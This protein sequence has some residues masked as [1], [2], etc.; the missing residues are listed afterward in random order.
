MRSTLSQC[1]SV[2]QLLSLQHAED[3]CFLFR[4]RAGN[5]CVLRLYLHTRLT[6]QK[7]LV[8][9]DLAC[10][11]AYHQLNSL[12]ATVPFSDWIPGLL[13]FNTAVRHDISR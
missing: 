5:N 1:G 8:G 7:L 10:L 9:L 3:A 6:L 4:L 12:V 11:H 13:P 2:Q